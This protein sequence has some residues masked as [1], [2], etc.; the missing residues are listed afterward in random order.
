MTSKD[1]VYV[2]LIVLTALIFYCHG[3]FSGVNRSRRIYEA[4]LGGPDSEAPREQA[5]GPMSRLSGSPPGLSSR[6]GSEI[7][8]DFGNN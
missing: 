5:S 8:G 2:G 7:R 4:L 1:L 6:R 3:F